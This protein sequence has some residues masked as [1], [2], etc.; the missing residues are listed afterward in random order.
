MKG[1]NSSWYLS[2]MALAVAGFIVLLPEVVSVVK[3]LSLAWR[4]ELS[5]GRAYYNGCANRN[6]PSILGDGFSRFA[7]IKG[8]LIIK[9]WGMELGV[10][11]KLLRGCFWK[12]NFLL[13]TKLS[14]LVTSGGLRGRK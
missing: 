3:S 10:V 7:S 11:R 12:V 1:M 13:E 4:T 9:L 6:G 8:R 5:D 2:S 14:C